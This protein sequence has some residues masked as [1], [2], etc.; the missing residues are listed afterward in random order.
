[1]TWPRPL[2]VEQAAAPRSRTPLRTSA[3]AVYPAM[4]QAS[5]VVKESAVARPVVVKA[6]AAVLPLGPKSILRQRMSVRRQVRS[7]MRRRSYRR[8]WRRPCPRRRSLTVPVRPPRRWQPLPSVVAKRQPR[9]RRSA[10][11]TQAVPVE[12][13]VAAPVAALVEVPVAVPVVAQEVPVALEVPVVAQAVLAAERAEPVE[14]RPVA[15]WLP[16]AAS[17]KAAVPQGRRLS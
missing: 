2:P 14:V 16:W 12:R 6:P 10:A 9:L 5:A 17:S 1:M 3:V 15:A 7:K 11:E 13:V 4:A 8:R